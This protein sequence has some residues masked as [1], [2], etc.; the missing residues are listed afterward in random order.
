LWLGSGSNPVYVRRSSRTVLAFAAVVWDDQLPEARRKDVGDLYARRALALL[1]ETHK[2]GLFKN[3]AYRDA[4]KNEK[5]YESLR[6]REEFTQ[7]LQDIE[8][9]QATGAPVAR[10]RVAG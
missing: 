6:P 3:P 4:L 1:S 9:R 7:L 2:A 5:T 10:C 8:P